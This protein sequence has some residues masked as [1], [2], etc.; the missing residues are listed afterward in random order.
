MA[1]KIASGPVRV[2]KALKPLCL[3]QIWSW[4]ISLFSLLAL[5]GNKNWLPNIKVEKLENLQDKDGSKDCKWSSLNAP[6]TETHLS[7]PDLE[8]DDFPFLIIS[9]LG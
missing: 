7:H 4:M 9:P 5:W 6:G 8:L 1:Q 3:I 2:P